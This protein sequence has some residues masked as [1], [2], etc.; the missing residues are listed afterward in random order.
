MHISYN[1]AVMRT[2][3]L[4]K[5]VQ[6]RLEKQAATIQAKRSTKRVVA[7][8]GFNTD[9][10]VVQDESGQWVPQVKP[11]RIQRKGK[12]AAVASVQRTLAHRKQYEEQM[13]AMANY[14]P[15]KDEELEA[16][17]E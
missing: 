12:S 5:D 16:N 2:F 6:A 3:G 11:H 1:D 17:A 4:W 13:R 10:T 14:D 8:D 9:V 7:A 15:N